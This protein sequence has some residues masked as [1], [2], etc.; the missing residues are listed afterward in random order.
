MT[1]I[2]NKASKVP[3]IGDNLKAL[4]VSTAFN[5]GRNGATSESAMADTLRTDNADKQN[6]AKLALKAGWISSILFA[7]VDVTPELEATCAAILAKKGWKA[8]DNDLSKR[9][10]ETEQKACRAADMKVNRL[11]IAFAITNLETRGGEPKL[12][13]SK[14]QL[15]KAAL[16]TLTKRVENVLGAA[17]AA[18]MMERGGKP[19]MPTSTVLVIPEFKNIGAVND[20]MAMLATLAS[21]SVDKATLLTSEQRKLYRSA[22]ASFKAEIGKLKA[23]PFKS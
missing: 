21:K 18:R 11:F 16:A 7:G 19:G 23:L 20:H 13:K 12:P 9:R 3:A 10:T 8:D 22:V 14:A 6:A 17:A 5:A 4:T 15:K 2:K 1:T